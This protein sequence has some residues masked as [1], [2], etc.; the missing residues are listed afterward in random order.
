MG[1]NELEFSGNTGE[2]PME[3]WILWLNAIHG[4]L[5][6]LS[7]QWGL[8]SGLGIVELTLLLRSAVLPLTWS[9]AY[10]GSF[11]QRKMLL[12]QPQLPARVI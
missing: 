5:E 1:A 9:V 11:R 10:R 6:I 8:G 7:T 2:M 3:L 4:L 12:L